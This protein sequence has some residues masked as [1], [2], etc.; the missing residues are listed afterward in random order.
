MKEVKV[1]RCKELKQLTYYDST[2]LLFQLENGI[3]LLVPKT[4]KHFDIIDKLIDCAEKVISNEE[5]N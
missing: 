4:Y 2:Y 3:A 1:E 5:L